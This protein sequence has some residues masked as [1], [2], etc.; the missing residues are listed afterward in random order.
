MTQVSNTCTYLK[1]SPLREGFSR[2]PMFLLSEY[3][4]L[5]SCAWPSLFSLSF[6]SCT[7]RRNEDDLRGGFTPW[8]PPLWSE[9]PLKLKEKKNVNNFSIF[10]NCSSFFLPRHYFSNRRNRLKR[11]SEISWIELT[12]Q[13]DYSSQNTYHTISIALGRSL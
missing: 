7:R 13:K 1:L 5:S 2:R 4:T 3:T 8:V 12:L 11:S 9:Q 10:F 6:T